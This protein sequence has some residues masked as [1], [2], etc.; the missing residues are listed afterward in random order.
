MNPFKREIKS[1]IGSLCDLGFSCVKAS[2][3]YFSLVANCS[4]NQSCGFSLS[5][6]LKSR[7]VD[8][9]PSSQTLDLTIQSID[10]VICPTT[11]IRN[12]ILKKIDRVY[13]NVIDKVFYMCV[14]H[15]IY[16]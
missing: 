6:S 15:P 11:Y 1:V 5:L 14:I 3:P 7:R 4:K 12:I 16:W 9:V 13:I 10:T 2:L 8:D